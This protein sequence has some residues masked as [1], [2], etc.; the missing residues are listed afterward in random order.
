MIDVAPQ[1]CMSLDCLIYGIKEIKS[2]YGK[3][4]RQIPI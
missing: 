4:L 3:K 2:L 1:M